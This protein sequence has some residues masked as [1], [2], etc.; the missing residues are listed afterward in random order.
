MTHSA[1]NLLWGLLEKKLEEIAKSVGYFE[2]PMGTR[3]YQVFDE[4]WLEYLESL[5]VFRCDPRHI[6]SESKDISMQDPLYTSGMWLRM[7]REVADK[8]L[9]IGLP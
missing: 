6:T 9:T 5:G 2:E 7:P 1:D 8:I 4:A 3:K